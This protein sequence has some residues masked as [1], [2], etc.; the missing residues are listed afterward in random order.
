MSSTSK[1]RRVVIVA[2]PQP[3]VA[4]AHSAIPV[5]VVNFDIVQ[6]P[7]E[8]DA[9]NNPAIRARFAREF[10]Q[11]LA[12]FRKCQSVLEVSEVV[13]I[14]TITPS[15]KLWLKTGPPPTLTERYS[16]VPAATIEEVEEEGEVL[17]LLHEETCEHANSPNQGTVEQE[18]ASGSSHVPRSPS[19]T[20]K[21]KQTRRT[22]SPPSQHP[23]HQPVERSRSTKSKRARVSRSPSPAYRCSKRTRDSRSPRPRRL[24]Q[25]ERSHPPPAASVHRRELTEDQ[26]YTS[27]RDGGRRRT[28]SQVQRAC[29]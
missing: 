25:V 7:R 14:V 28:L 27:R 9:R 6:Q 11:K 24:R 3:A 19:P 22:D 29:W 15:S 10:Q 20:A 23:E 21:P 4:H 2:P 5:R 17:Q 1:N 26:R 18:E 13:F 16:A 8:P 12:S